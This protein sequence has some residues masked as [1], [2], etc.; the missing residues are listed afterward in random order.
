VRE[1]MKISDI[2]N[3][4]STTGYK[5]ASVLVTTG[6]WFW[7]KSKRVKIYKENM[8]SYWRFMDSGEY[9]PDRDVEKLV[10]AYEAKKEISKAG[11]VDAKTKS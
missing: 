8:S 5:F 10:S 11:S 7:R 6:Y 9:T 4:G 2:Q 3:I 1:V